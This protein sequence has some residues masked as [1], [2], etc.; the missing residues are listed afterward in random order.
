MAIKP[1]KTK[2]ADP[3]PLVVIS[4]A[5]VVLATYR[6]DVVESL[7]Y[8]VPRLTRYE[9]LPRRLALLAT[10]RQEGVTYLSRGLA[11]TFAH[12]LQATVCAVELNW[13]W[14]SPLP[15]GP[16][17]GLAGVLGGTASLED[18]LVWTS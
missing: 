10:L 8:I 2:A 5:N 14:P 16:Q 12:D 7:R 11:A 9:A 17:A 4:Q 6:Y 15:V 3:E 18:A 13:W 1:K